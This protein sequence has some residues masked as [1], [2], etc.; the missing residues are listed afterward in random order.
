MNTNL[1]KISD[2]IAVTLKQM[3]VKHAF[4]IIGY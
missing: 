2:Q 3:G 4:G 1:V